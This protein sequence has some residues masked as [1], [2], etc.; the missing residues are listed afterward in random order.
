MIIKIY[1]SMGIPTTPPLWSVDLIIQEEKK[2]S[3]TKNPVSPAI[4]I[5]K[6][7][8]L[9][10]CCRALI[11]RKISVVPSTISIA[12]LALGTRSKGLDP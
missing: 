5:G 4:I 10:T 6:F 3:P 11:S 1:G 8:L 7:G 9:M 2:L 12:L